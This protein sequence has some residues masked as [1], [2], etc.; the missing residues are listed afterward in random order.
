MSTTRRLTAK[1]GG[2]IQ[3]CALAG[4]HRSPATPLPPCL[5]GCRARLA[6]A[7]PGCWD[8][9]A[10]SCPRERAQR[11]SPAHA[12]T[13][14]FPSIGKHGAVV[15]SPGAC[16]SASACAGEPGSCSR[17]SACRSHMQT[18]VTWTG[19]PCWGRGR[20]RL[21]CWRGPRR[22]WTRAT[23]TLTLTPVPTWALAPDLNPD[24]SP[25]HQVD[26]TLGLG[27]AARGWS[28]REKYGE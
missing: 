17:G 1:P 23:L 28:V 21:S 18:S 13:L 27:L 7:A 12:S 9:A 19:C 26:S 11:R 8:R 2:S 5:L 24:A 22:R 25:A 4:R 14:P 6:P 15:F 3:A 16:G 20:G 10:R